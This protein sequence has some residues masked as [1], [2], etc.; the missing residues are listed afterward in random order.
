MAEPPI[1]L[2]GFLSYVLMG[3]GVDW[4]LVGALTMGAVVAGPLAAKATASMGDGRIMRGVGVLMVF[5]G[6]GTLFRVCSS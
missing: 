1:C 3:S 5:L 4:W 2:V 6:L